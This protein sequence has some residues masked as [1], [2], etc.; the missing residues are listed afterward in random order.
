S[1]MVGP[2]LVVASA[3]GIE[4]RIPVV[5]IVRAYR[6]NAMGPAEKAGLYAARVWEFVSGEPR[7]S[8]TEGGIFPAIFGTVLMVLIM[9]VAVVPIG[10]LAAVYLKEYAGEGWF[11]SAMRIFIRNLAGV[12]SIVFGV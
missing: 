12:P 7:E 8:N 9:T 6:P 4:K 10:V 3:E 5:E 11:V 1:R 2:A